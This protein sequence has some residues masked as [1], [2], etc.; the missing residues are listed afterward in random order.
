MIKD[1]NSIIKE[2]IDHGN[3]FHKRV[4]PYFYEFI[5]F[6]NTENI[7]YYLCGGTLLG[8]IRHK[9]KIPWDDDYDI[10]MNKSEIKRLKK[11]SQSSN[12]VNDEGPII[13]YLKL[14]NYSYVLVTNLKK[15]YQL[16]AYKEGIG[17]LEKITDIFNENDSWYSRTK[18][19]FV[20]NP[21][22]YPFH[23]LICNVSKNFDKELRFYYGN[24]MNEYVVTNHKVSI[25]NRDKNKRI[26]LTK[27]E[28]N[29]IMKELSSK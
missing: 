22:K 3:S 6:L 21:I 13:C 7:L 4:Y 15:I 23:D 2:F 14:K 18:N 9:G 17:I 19:F 26:I 5:N 24:Y 28:F 11:Y 29:K 27:D 25:Y 8:C 20:P 12:I 1:K 16:F 10:Y